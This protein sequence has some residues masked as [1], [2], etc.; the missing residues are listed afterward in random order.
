MAVESNFGQYNKQIGGGPALGVYQMEPRTLQCIKD[1]YIK[2]HPELKQFLTGDLLDERYA[3]IMCA[4]H[5][6]RYIKAIDVPDDRAGRWLIY[7]KY[8]NTD[9]GATV[10]ESYMSK[11]NLYI[12][13]E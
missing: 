8:Y 12:G 4:I 9:D 5:Y 10:R 13:E 1:N 3:T 6:Q 11:A 7:K 2:Y